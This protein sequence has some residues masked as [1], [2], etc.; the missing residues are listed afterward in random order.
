MPSIERDIADANENFHGSI[1][2]TFKPSPE[3]LRRDDPFAYAS[4]TLVPGE[5]FQR[6]LSSKITLVSASAQLM[7]SPLPSLYCAT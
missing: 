4:S 7:P 3:L 5:V 6:G 2:E 1:E